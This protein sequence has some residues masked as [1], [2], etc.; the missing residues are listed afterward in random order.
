MCCVL[1]LNF[2]VPIKITVTFAKE[3]KKGE[4]TKKNQEK[5][6]KRQEL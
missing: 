4:K 6:K 2:M 1:V 3:W 5:L